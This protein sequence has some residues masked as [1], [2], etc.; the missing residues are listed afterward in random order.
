MDEEFE[1]DAEAAANRKAQSADGDL[2]DE[3]L[4]EDNKIK[5][6]KKEIETLRSEKQENMDGWQRS[7]ADYVN[8]LRRFEEEKKSAKDAGVE[9]AVEALLPAFDAMERAK[10]HGEVP[11]GFE[12]IVRQLE[13]AFAALGLQSVG[14]VGDHFDPVIHEAL[15]QDV[16]ATEGEVDTVTAVLETG[17]KRG[18]RIIR[19]A[20]VKVG[21]LA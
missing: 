3:E 15:G 6:L 11:A 17:W 10:A 18:E 1:I 5:K 7:K 14:A 8:A 20:K 12:A 16:V 4:L 19:P 13:S 2:A 9:K 21:R